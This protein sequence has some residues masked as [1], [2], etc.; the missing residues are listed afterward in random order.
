M[1]SQF[2]ITEQNEKTLF[3]QVNIKNKITGELI[4]ILPNLGARLNSAE[5]KIE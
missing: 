3:H 5:F 2:Q 1:N 4:S